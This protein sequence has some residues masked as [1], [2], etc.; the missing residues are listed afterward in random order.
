MCSTSDFD[1]DGKPEINTWVGGRR[2][3]LSYLSIVFIS[4]HLRFWSVCFLLFRGLWPFNDLSFRNPILP[5]TAPQHSGFKLFM[6]VV[7]SSWII[8][9]K[10]KLSFVHVPI[11]SKCVI[12]FCS[13]MFVSIFV[14]TFAFCSIGFHNNDS[15]KSSRNVDL[16][17]QSIHFIILQ[18]T[19]QNMHKFQTFKMRLVQE[20]NEKDSVRRL[21]IFLTCWGIIQNYYTT[22]IFSIHTLNDGVNRNK[23][24]ITWTHGWAFLM[25]ISSD[26]FSQTKIGLAIF[27]YKC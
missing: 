22:F 24:L 10:N 2:M 5:R 26:L 13:N 11:T 18:V 25:T 16:I 20:L 4:A 7:T 12:I 21:N 14:N 23:C 1:K 8:L 27:T 17:H 15:N 19:K 6:R 9:I 3:R